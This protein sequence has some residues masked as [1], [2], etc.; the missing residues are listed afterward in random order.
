VDLWESGWPNG[1]FYWTVVPVLYV[2][3]NGFPVA[4]TAAAALGAPTIT[5]DAP[6]FTPGS[7][8]IGVGAGAE[9]V[10]V[11]TVSG[12]TLTLAAPLTRPHAVAE[13][14]TPTAGSLKYYDAETPQDTCAAGRVLEF[15]K[16]SEP[17]VSSAGSPYASGLSPR[18]LLTA[19]A[20]SK[21]AFYGT[22]LVAWSPALGADQY[23][24]QWSK[25]SYPWRKEGEKL[26][27]ATSAMLPLDPGKWFYRVRGINFSLPGTARAMTWSKPVGLTVSRP[28]FTVV[29]KS[30]R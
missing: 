25:T 26:T 8:V 4:L 12:T 1:R 30:G 13:A 24:V 9:S 17:V 11:T 23:Q 7:A 6:G 15:G 18:G 20:S 27:Y 2:A 14:V 5:V 19:A 22:P 16:T 3:D 10:T 29:K 28:T 21:P